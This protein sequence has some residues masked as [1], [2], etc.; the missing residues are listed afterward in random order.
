L[1]DERGYLSYDQ[2]H[3]VKVNATTLTPWGVRLGTR[4]N[5]ESGL[6]YSILRRDFSYSTTPPVY[7]GLAPPDSPV[8]TRYATGQRNDHRNRPFWNVD[9]K[10]SKEFSLPKGM[11]MQLSAEIFN[12]LNDDTYTVY[13]NAQ[14]LGQQVNGR[15][16]AYRRFGRTFQLGMR[17]S[18]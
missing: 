3:V 17:L 4:V 13:N 11:N 12:L 8:R 1:E 5:W 10:A 9:V 7:A 6:P 16:E 15:N 14:N 18:F 2:R